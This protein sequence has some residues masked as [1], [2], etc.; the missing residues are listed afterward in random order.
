MSTYYSI[1]E[2]VTLCWCRTDLDI[3]EELHVDLV[4]EILGL[5]EK[6]LEVLAGS[7]LLSGNV[8]ALVVVLLC[9]CEVAFD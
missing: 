3:V 9:Q 4:G 7:V 1:A 5:S 2:M 6:G 8:A